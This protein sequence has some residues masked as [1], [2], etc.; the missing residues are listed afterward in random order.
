MVTFD[1]QRFVFEGNCEYILATV[2]PWEK[3]RG[4]WGGHKE[5][6]G[7]VGGH[8]GAKRMAWGDHTGLLAGSSVPPP[9]RTAAAPM[10]RSPPSRS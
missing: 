8:R 1:G 7:E 6:L 10:I 9:H 4:S 5:T 3:G 2:R